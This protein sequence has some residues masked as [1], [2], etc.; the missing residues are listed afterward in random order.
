MYDF[1]DHVVPY[2]K[3]AF[4]LDADILLG[5]DWASEEFLSKSVNQDQVRYGFD[6]KLPTNTRPFGLLEDYLE[7]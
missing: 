1:D 7:T 2:S 4:N 5:Q 3:T 6:P